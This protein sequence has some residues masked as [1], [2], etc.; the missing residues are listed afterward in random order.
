MRILFV[1]GLLVVVAVAGGW[2]AGESWLARQ[3]A[4][5]AEATA[6]LAMAEARPLRAP[7]RIGIA[8]REPEWSEADRGLA[9]PRLDLWISPLS[10]TELRASL[11]DSATLTVEGRDHPVGLT[12]GA[13]GLAVS[14][15]H[16]GAIRRAA[17]Q[18][19]MLTLDGAP[20]AE[21]LSVEAEM[22]RL[23]HD[24][25][26]GARAAY[27]LAL[28]LNGMRPD[29]L[30]GLGVPPVSLQGSVSVTGP[31]RLW[32]GDILDVRAVSGARPAP[33]LVGLRSEGIDVTIGGATARLAGTIRAGADGLAEG[34]LA[35]YSR[36]SGAWLQAASEAGLIPPEG[37]MLAAALVAGLGRLSFPEGD[38][39]EGLALP[40]PAPDEVRL[41][42]VM[43]GGRLMMGNIDLGAAP[44]LG[45]LR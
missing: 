13:L 1:L 40:E 26:R 16:G 20:L 12:G 30:A 11:P 44:D 45:W 29:G 36:N 9:M 3:A 42:V 10:P 41:P 7:P 25:P 14:V 18:A 37:A 4:T 33:A 8:L 34:R 22:T 15:L 23:G 24:A 2:L 19:A 39:A 27:D 21:A 6:G 32:L 43:R 35:I 5:G 31:L 38:E 28:S 17:A